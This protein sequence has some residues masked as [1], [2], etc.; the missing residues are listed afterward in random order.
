VADDA[1]Q[2]RVAAPR[3]HRSPTILLTWLAV[4]IV[5]TIVVVLVAVKLAT[6]N[7]STATEPSVDPASSGLVSQVT[8]I[9]RSVYDT[10]GVDSPA[11]PVSPPAAV[12]GKSHLT[13]DGKPAVVFVGAE[14]CAF[15]AADRWA[16][17]ASLSRFG[18]FT[19]LATIR[20]S[21]TAAPG[22]IES[23]TFRDATYS[24]RYLTLR[25]VEERSDYNP[26]GTS[27]TVLQQPDPFEQQVLSSFHATGYP[28]IDFGNAYAV[29]G[30]SY[31]PTFLSGLTW[32]EIGSSLTD[33]T[34]AV[35]RAIVALS[36]YYSASTCAA[37]GQQ[38]ASV[39]H[40]KGVLAATHAMDAARH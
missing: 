39:C 5:L 38:P 7:A 1:T 37:T 13:V 3:R 35:T 12:T 28:F 30:V 14:F 33:P 36:N 29:T 40:S 9:P 34:Q 16:L 4:A 21:S 32:D 24:S 20:S 8:S 25:T 23:F 31:S 27:Y 17:I 2:V 22:G 18:H 11:V 26:T 6:P 15:C 10:V 19:G